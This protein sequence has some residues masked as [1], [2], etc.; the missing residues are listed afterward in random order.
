MDL[1]DAN[2]SKKKCEGSF[3]G[4]VKCFNFSQ[5]GKYLV[6]ASQNN[7]ELV[8]YDI[9]SSVVDNS[10]TGGDDEG[11]GGTEKIPILC[12]LPLSGI[13]NNIQVY[14]NKRTQQLYA[15]VIF[16][17]KGACVL[18]YTIPNK[19]QD[20]STVV[21]SKCNITLSQ[22]DVQIFAMAF[23]PNAY[24]TNKNNTAS[25]GNNAIPTVI[26][27]ATGRKSSAPQFHEVYCEDKSNNML[28]KLEISVTVKEI[29]GSIGHNSSNNESTNKATENSV[30]VAPQAAILGP[31]N[32][33][34]VLVRPTTEASSS[35]ENGT[36]RKRAPSE[37][38]TAIATAG[39][40]KKNKKELAEEAKKSVSFLVDNIGDVNNRAAD[41]TLEERLQLLT[42]T[43]V[44]EDNLDSEIE[45]EE[46]SSDHEKTD[47]VLIPTSDSLVVL[48]EQ[49][50][51]SGDDVLLEQCLSCEDSDIVDAT[52]KRIPITK[53]VQFLR[54][55]IAKFEKRPSRG[56]LLTNWLSCIM[57]HHLSYL[58]S[59]PDLA[60]QLA[61]LAQMLENRLSTYTRLASL[62]GRLDL[63]IGLTKSDKVSKINKSTPLVFHA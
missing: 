32:A 56:I 16:E 29:N 52:A 35:S 59:I 31:L 51:Q 11:V 4:G 37:D 50:L 36:N 20:K 13:A 44:K 22:P 23:D 18:K 43:L 55:L 21:Y 42:S 40:S 61:G 63:L 2:Y 41:V 7:R 46:E 58:I 48:L 30:N 1:S 38:L 33:T 26:H 49:A 15:A 60:V 62:A 10:N 34:A 6:C 3:A 5:C 8:I 54:K 9:E 53:I 28:Q 45:D 19:N 17:D 24:N 39:S 25:N 12:T 14:M 57:K 47:L 27:L